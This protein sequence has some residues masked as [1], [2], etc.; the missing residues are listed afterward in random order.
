M[1][2][3]VAVPEQAQQTRCDWHAKVMQ[4]MN[5]ARR[6]GSDPLRQTE[7]ENQDAFITEMRE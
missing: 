5:L 6:K 1:D 4:K 3:E 7:S 2:L